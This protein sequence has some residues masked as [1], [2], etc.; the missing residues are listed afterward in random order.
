[1]AHPLIV[2]GPLSSVTVRSPPSLKV[3]A[4]LTGVIVIVAVCAVE[5]SLPPLLVPPSSTAVTVMVAVPL[6][7]AAGVKVRVPAV[8]IAGSAA[9]SAGWSTVTVKPTFCADSF[10]GPAVMPLA[11]PLIV[12]RAA[13]LGRR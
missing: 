8:S 9:N 11:Q 7:S 4:S 1:M 2:V 12:D 10:D 13:V 5:V 3:G 6:A